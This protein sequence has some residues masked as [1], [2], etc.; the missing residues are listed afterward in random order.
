[1]IKI[2]STNHKL[3]S[4]EIEIDLKLIK[5]NYEHVRS[6]KKVR[7]TNEINGLFYKLANFS[8]NHKKI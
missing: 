6:L 2:M 1:M 3:Q 8:Y 5:C 7:D 4:L